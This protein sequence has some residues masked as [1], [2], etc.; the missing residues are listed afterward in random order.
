MSRCQRSPELLKAAELVDQLAQAD[1]SRVSKA[2]A[3][4]M[5]SWALKLTQP[6]SL[7]GDQNKKLESLLL[8]MAEAQGGAG[9]PVLG[10][11]IDGFSS[12]IGPLRISAFANGVPFIWGF[13][14]SV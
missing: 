5:E 11:L 8:E 7:G 4:L 1:R 13:F 12:S 2:Y 9:M 14:F 3:L 6:G 10:K